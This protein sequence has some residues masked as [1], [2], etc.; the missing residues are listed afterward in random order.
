MSAPQDDPSGP[1]AAPLDPA[2]PLARALAA[3]PPAPPPPPV[4]LVWARIDAGAPADEPAGRPLPHLLRRRAAALTAAA[5]VLVAAGILVAT[6]TDRP[7]A[8]REVRVVPV[9]GGARLV[10]GDAVL[11]F[12]A[13][14]EGDVVV[15]GDGAT[16]TVRLGERVTATLGRGA[17]LA[18]ASEGEVRLEAGTASFEV[19]PSSAATAS[20]AFRV[21][22]D[23]RVVTDRG[24]RFVVA[25]VPDPEAPW[26]AVLSVAVEEG[27][28]EVD[29]VPVAAGTGWAGPSSGRGEALAAR[30]AP[31]VPPL[32]SLE[33]AAEA[34][35][36]E[37][38]SVRL[39]VVNRSPYPVARPA[40]DDVSAPMLLE[41]TD[42]EGVARTVRVTR[43][44]IVE[45]DGVEAPREGEPWLAP[46]VFPPPD[47]DP[48]ARLL[49]ARFA[50]LFPARGT[51]R[52]R[53]LHATADGASADATPVLPALAVDVR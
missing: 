2:D 19:G 34:R 14:R 37:P 12:G 21:L 3:L 6:R 5:A 30:A 52:L 50:S 25:R 49:T 45:G 11:S 20:P 39:L 1:F 47:G 38:A 10:R 46:A 42:P 13:A 18:L 29:G 26:E 31:L 40:R 23:D 17:A 7:P 15:A 24:T 35:A 9:A 43:E 22:V 53:V 16:A 28:V 32:V 44:V 36:G 8:P 48:P 41:V 51:Y 33:L 27:V 4:A